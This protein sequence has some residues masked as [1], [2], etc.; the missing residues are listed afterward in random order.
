M[1]TAMKP[2]KVSPVLMPSIPR[3]EAKDEVISFRLP[4][5]LK[6]NIDK[7]LKALG[8]PDNRKA[9]FYRGAILAAIGNCLRAQD[10]SWQS[11]LEAL[12]PLAQKH[13]GM[14]LGDSG[15]KGILD[16]GGDLL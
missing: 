1:K 2:K 16:E 5:R 12:Q 14:G 11:F 3:A 6:A 13:L 9:E 15:L 10:A 4:A 7:H 8:V